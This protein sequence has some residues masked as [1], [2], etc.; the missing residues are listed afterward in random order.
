M[1][2]FEP[3]RRRERKEIFLKKKTL[4][5]LRLCGSKHFGQ[6]QSHLLIRR[7]VKHIFSNNTQLHPSK[8]FFVVYPLL[9]IEGNM[10]SGELLFS[11]H[12][13]CIVDGNNLIARMKE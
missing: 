3:Q 9:E 2:F 10:R 12:T 8:G 4:H 1:I 5:S 6:H 11:Q 13:R 7:K